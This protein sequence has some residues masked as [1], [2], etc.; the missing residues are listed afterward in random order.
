MKRVLTWVEVAFTLFYLIFYTGGPIFLILSNGYSEGDSLGL[1]APV[2]DFS[3]AKNIFL[4]NYVATAGLLALRWQQALKLVRREAWLPGIIVFAGLSL[5][6]SVDPEITKTRAI[7][8]LGTSLFGL[9]IA[10][11]YSLRQQCYLIASALGCA[12]VLS[13]GFALL[14]PEYGI[15]GG[16]HAGAWRGIYTHKSNLGKVMALAASLF[17]LLLGDARSWVGKLLLTGGLALATGLLILS[18]STTGLVNGC[19]LLILI[20]LW[21]V[22]RFR[23]PVLLPVLLVGA[24]G[25]IA[26]FYTV[27]LRTETVLGWLKKDITLTGRTELWSILQDVIGRRPWLGY[28]FNGFWESGWGSPVAEVWRAVGWQAPSAHNAWIDIWLEL[29]LVGLVLFSLSLVRV[30]AQAMHWGRLSSTAADFWPLLL[31]ST[32]LIGSITENTILAENDIFWVLYCA[33]VFSLAQSTVRASAAARGPGALSGN[34]LKLASSHTNTFNTGPFKTGPFNTGP[35]NTDPFN[36]SSFTTDPSPPPQAT[37]RTLPTSAAFQAWA[38]GELPSPQASGTAHDFTGKADALSTKMPLVRQKIARPNLSRLWQPRH[39]KLPEGSFFRGAAVE[40]VSRMLRVAI[41]ASYFVLL[42]RTLGVQEYGIFM[43][44]TATV[45]L[46]VPFCALGSEHLIVKNMAQNREKFPFFFGH[47]LLT[48]GLFSSFFTLVVVAIAHLLFRDKVST[49][50]LFLITLSDLFFLKIIEICQNIFF[51]LSRTLEAS[52]LSIVMSLK[53]LFAILW[54]IFL[55]SDKSIE[56]WAFHYCIGT[57]LGAIASCILCALMLGLPK[58]STQKFWRDWKEGLYFSVGMSAQNVN[59]NIDKTMLLQ[60]ASAGDTG[61]YAAAYRIIS[62]V[63]TPI[64]SLMAISYTKFFSS[65]AAGLQ[66]SLGFARQI[67]PVAAL[68]G[69]FSTMLL[70]LFAPL[71]VFVFGS[72][73]ANCVEAIRWLSPLLLIYSVKFLLEDSLAGAGLQRTRSF[74]QIGAA[75]VNVLLNFWLLPTFSWKGAAWSSLASETVL[76]LMLIYFIRRYSRLEKA[77]ELSV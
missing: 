16:T 65:G 60:Y 63:F 77:A 50:F 24:G 57:V 61:I 4:L 21:R 15:M 40:L 9:Y 37:V 1:D 53:N 46:V 6:W 43:S 59:S 25:A 23:A 68:Y 67:L 11:R 13:L 28:G 70:A 8:L 2:F 17:L 19:F 7:A 75:L 71:T 74:L 20:P 5:L 58:F 73:Y 39:W 64:V 14:L 41:Q 34:P 33:I 66:G 3:L 48:T 62:I 38:R 22:L 29:G 45:A 49:S 36:T 47:S 42:T 10:S 76:I 27:W 56:N 72:E 30:V 69:I 31:L 18:Q 52:L 44:I 51:A 54:F 12:T 55:A 35:F 32:M 26:S